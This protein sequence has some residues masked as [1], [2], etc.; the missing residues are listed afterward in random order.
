MCLCTV[1]LKDIEHMKVIPEMFSGTWW[2]RRLWNTGNWLN[3][4]VYVSMLQNELLS[5]ASVDKKAGTYVP[6]GNSED[7]LSFVG[8]FCIWYSNQNSPQCI[9][10]LLF[11]YL[12]WILALAVGNGTY[13]QCG[14]LITIL[15]DPRLEKLHHKMPQL[16]LNKINPF[17]ICAAESFSHYLWPF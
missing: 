1:L 2:D 12:W 6:A 16:H 7:H 13:F 4:I 17:F 11:T 10:R 15:N 5:A 3:V 14:H 9:V 8:S